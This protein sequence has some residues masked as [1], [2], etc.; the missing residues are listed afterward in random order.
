MILYS[1]ALSTPLTL[2]R[3]L[4]EKDCQVSDFHA[5]IGRVPGPKG[6][7]W[8]QKHLRLFIC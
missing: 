8:I 7:F 1:K 5:L 6:L 2:L 4:P 3:C